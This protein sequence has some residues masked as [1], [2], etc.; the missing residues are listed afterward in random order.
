MQINLARGDITAQAVDAIVDAANS[1]LMG[2]R[3]GRRHPPARRPGHPGGMPGT[4]STST[5]R[6]PRRQ[7]ASSRAPLTTGSLVLAHQV[8]VAGA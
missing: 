8:D 7:I 5:W 2:G 1:S 6:A 4:A 3:R